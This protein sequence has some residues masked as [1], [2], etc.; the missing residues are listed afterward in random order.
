M[1]MSQRGAKV[2][3]MV[4]AATLLG[5]LL[6]ALT[7]IGTAGQPAQAAEDCPVDQGA[8]PEQVNT[9]LGASTVS[10]SYT[11]GWNAIGAVRDGQRVFAGGANNQMWGTYTAA[12]RP[13]EQWLQ[14]DWTESRVLTGASIAFARDAESDTAGDGLAVPSSWRLQSWNGSDWADVALADGSAFTRDK[15]A[16]NPVTFAAPV[17]TTR[18]RA[19]FAATSDGRTY[20]A[21]AVSE[22]EATGAPTTTDGTEWLTSSAFNVG[23]SRKTGGV[24]HLGNASD[25]PYCTNYVANPTVRPEF[26]VDDSRWLGDVGM[27]INGQPRMTSLS[28]DIRSVTKDGDSITVSYDGDAQ[29]ANGI[30]GFGLDETYSLTGADRDV[31]DWKLK[32]ANT[33]DAPMTVEDLGLPLLMNAWWDG[34]NQTGIY[35]QNV[36]RHSFVAEDGSYMVWKRPNGEGPFLVMVPQ[37]GTSLEFK[38][39]ARPGEGTFA[40]RDPSWE[41]LVEYY[42]HSEHIAPLRAGAEQAAQYLPATSATI[43]PGA[44]KTYGFTF[45]W[46]DD[47]ADMRDVLY[48]AGVV[49]VL[50]L[51]GMTIPQDTKATLAVRA[52]DGIDSVIAGG[53]TSSAGSDSV[54]VPVGEKNG[55]QLYDVTFPTLGENFVT[56][57]YA[58]GK[59]SVLQYYSIEP[60]EQLIDANAD[61]IAGNQQ[62]KDPSKGYD[63]AF[64]QWD[65]RTKQIITRDTFASAAVAGIDEFRMRWMTGGS[66]DVGLSPAAFLAEKNA[67]SPDA[68]EVESLDYYIDNFILGYLQN[69]FA[70]GER[71]W[72]LYHWYDGGDGDRPAT[73]R[74]DGTSPGVGDGLATWR[75]MNSPH[76][77]NTYYSMYK[78]AKQYPDL[79]ERPAAEYL[80]MSYRT[81]K[82]YFEHTDAG[83]FL[84]GSSIH[85][86]S[87]GE[88][89]YPLIE[90]S[91]RS[92]GRASEADLLVSYFKVK[93]EGFA[94]QKYPFA[95]EM[96]IDTTA[97]ETNYT[98]AKMF[99]DQ[100]LARKVTLA[101]LAARGTQP[102]WY[103]YGSDTR[104]MGESWWNLSY[105]TQLGAWQQ[106]DYAKNSDPAADGIDPDELMRST[107]GA[108]LAGWA[109]I[110][111]GQISADPANY[112]AASWVYN[113]E[114]GSSDYAFIP[115]IDG[116]WAW[117]GESA[118]G[119][120]GALHTASVNVVDDEVV[121]VYGYG[122]EVAVTDT[123]YTVTPKDGVRQRLNVFPEGKLAIELSNAKYTE[124]V[125]E[126]GLG[127]VTLTL[128]D[129]D[130]KAVSPTVTMRN[131][132]AGA[133]DVFV[134]DQ[135]VLGATA[136][137]L[138]AGVALPTPGEGAQELRVV[139]AEGTSTAPV[140]AVEQ[141]SVAA[142]GSVTV[143]GSGFD[144]GEPVDLVLNSD[145]VSLGDVMADAAGSFAVI[146]TVP[147][148]VNTGPHTLVAT[149]RESTRQAF[150]ALEVTAVM[151]G[152]GAS[153]GG[154]SGGSGTTSA[155]TV[156]ASARPGGLASTGFAGF[157]LLLAGG[158]ALAGG[159]ALVARARE[160][161]VAS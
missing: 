59:T 111:S 46:A 17:E 53:G 66:D 52:K 43:E 42:I 10:A 4:S 14:Y 25:A 7:S 140:V 138:A 67:L 129:A 148:V 70:D 24:Y 158:M 103:H 154:A 88:L 112:G 160:R 13:A 2:A 121:G 40:E 135:L 118:L 78:I 5:A 79:A 107:Y 26:D 101:S 161:R 110:N 32:L 84:P 92:E 30:R 96:S 56:V 149:G 100:S 11:A 102:L 141:S 99:G 159:A 63:G 156:S 143:S 109:N 29:N 48:E 12:D 144:A 98:L 38:D 131:L 15:D 145:P 126:K 18:L 128:E 76:V 114:K 20:A 91:L 9:A 21:V 134:D 105:E 6:P 117:S 85:L 51:P 41:G 8:A 65:M 147:L 1:S 39:K 81:M 113:S 122:G 75:V 72:N 151:T 133:Y 153:G 49:D 115:K 55:Y 16:D 150:A 47:Y 119:F 82:A 31:L 69:Q 54:I 146:V 152:G 83:Y 60:V 58:G 137:E 19:V 22:F 57:N 97:F 64:L 125:V 27:R 132:P 50:S 106:Q 127:S 108:Y 74:D 157:G 86:G 80:D 155:G 3:A 34:G 37:D 33:A 93:Y 44:D 73:G 136:A 142:G 23:I 62:A 124:A 90:A 71:T 28:D 36:G 95:S 45:R 35:E 61:F 130:R 120:W 77:W 89:S 68:G 104:H 116:W 87:M 94:A 139:L 123:T